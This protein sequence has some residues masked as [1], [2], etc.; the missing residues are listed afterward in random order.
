MRVL[1]QLRVPVNLGQGATFSKIIQVHC[2]GP[3]AW[4]TNDP[5]TK[6][7]VR[8]LDIQVQSRLHAFT[9]NDNLK[10]YNV[11]D[12]RLAKLAETSEGPAS[13]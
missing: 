6:T 11:V 5:T 8:K 9:Y 3:L 7:S 13:K 2:L 12:R 1:A 10:I 4:I